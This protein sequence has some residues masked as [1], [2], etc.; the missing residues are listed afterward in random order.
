M[1]MDSDTLPG[2]VF[3][4]FE[5]AG[6]PERVATE[7]ALRIDSPEFLDHALATADAI[8][9][10]CRAARMPDLAPGFVVA[11]MA[12]DQVGR[13]LM[14]AMAERDEATHT[15]TSRRIP[16]A[17]LAANVWAQRNPRGAGA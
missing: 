12:P 7:A 4:A 17:E 15:D 14:D 16:S 1:P 9:A 8:R 13:I 3:N 11:G 2:R 5:A 10:R 6:W